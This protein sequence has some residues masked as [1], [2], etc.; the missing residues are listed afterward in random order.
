MLVEVNTC[1]NAIP[2]MSRHTRLVCWWLVYRVDASRNLT[3]EDE[4]AACAHAKMPLERWLAVRASRPREWEKVL[5]KRKRR[6]AWLRKHGSVPD[7][8][9][10]PNPRDRRTA[11]IPACIARRRIL[12]DSLMQCLTRC[13]S[14]ASI[15]AHQA[16]LGIGGTA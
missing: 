10:P 11:N 14:A 8:W 2:T 7:G 12:A 4:A 6:R 15:A 1:I 13:N 9:T 3:P 16:G 5:A